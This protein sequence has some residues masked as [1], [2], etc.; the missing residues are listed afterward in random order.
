MTKYH[1]LEKCYGTEW[2]L[3]ADVMYIVT[4]ILQL[5]NQLLQTP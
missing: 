5:K 1:F 4:Q 3:R 2:P